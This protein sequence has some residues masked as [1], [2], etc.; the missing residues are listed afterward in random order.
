MFPMEE[1][2]DSNKLVP[3]EGPYASPFGLGVVPRLFLLAASLIVAVVAAVMAWRGSRVQPPPPQ[4]QAP[5][6]TPSATIT[7]DPTRIDSNQ[8]PKQ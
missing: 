1:P 8:S 3:G 6:A 7:P 4:P 5:R 2:Y